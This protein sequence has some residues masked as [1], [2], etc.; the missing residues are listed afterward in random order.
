M[1]GWSKARRVL[2]VWKT[3][4]HNNVQVTIGC[5]VIKHASAMALGIG[6]I[7]ESIIMLG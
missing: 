3:E 4:H 7:Y 2:S 5:E 1:R 6:N